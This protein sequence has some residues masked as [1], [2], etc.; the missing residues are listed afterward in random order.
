MLEPSPSQSHNADDFLPALTGKTTMWV[1]R[2]SGLL[3]LVF[4]FIVI[5]QFGVVIRWRMWSGWMA[6]TNERLSPG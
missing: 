6:Q 2:T 5:K 4:L 1:N 3:H